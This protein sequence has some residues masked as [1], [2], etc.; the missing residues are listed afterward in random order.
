[1]L[2]EQGLKDG[3]RDLG[4]IRTILKVRLRAAEATLAKAE[5]DVTELR[6][7]VGFAAGQA[8]ALARHLAAMQAAAGQPSSPT[9]PE[10]PS[11]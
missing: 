6:K 9:A 7:L 5:V 1:M 10:P 2:S 3:I 8:D 11:L 4:Q